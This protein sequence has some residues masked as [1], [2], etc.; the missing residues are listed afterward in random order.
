VVPYVIRAGAELPEFRGDGL[1]FYVALSLVW[2]SF[3]RCVS[4]FAPWVLSQEASKEVAMTNGYFSVPAQYSRP[5]FAQLFYLWRPS[6]ICSQ[7]N[8]NLNPQLCLRWLAPCSLS[9][10]TFRS[11]DGFCYLAS[12]LRP[13]NAG[14]LPGGAVGLTVRIRMDGLRETKVS[15]AEACWGVFLFC[16]RVGIRENLAELAA[17]FH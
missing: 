7:Q 16:L 4:G 3:Q 8:W 9:A 17:K 1:C 15:V 2:A 14:V 5:V 6:P 11:R 10:R 13:M 12:A